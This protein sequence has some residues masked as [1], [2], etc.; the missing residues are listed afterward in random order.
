MTESPRNPDSVP[1]STAEHQVVARGDS[2]VEEGV[3]GESKVVI[4]MAG[5]ADGR[6]LGLDEPQDPL[7]YVPALRFREKHRTKVES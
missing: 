5:D 4:D 1:S 7:R 3:G 6:V 2:R